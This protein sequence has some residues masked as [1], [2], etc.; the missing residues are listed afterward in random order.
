[1][2]DTITI[3]GT[4]YH[5]LV[6]FKD[7]ASTGN[8]GGGLFPWALV[9]YDRTK[10]LNDH[11]TEDTVD[12]T[13]ALSFNPGYFSENTESKYISFNQ[14]ENTPLDAIGSYITGHE[15]GGKIY[16]KLVCERDLRYTE[17]EQK[18]PSI[19]G[20]CTARAGLGA[21]QSLYIQ[22]GSSSNNAKEIL[23]WKNPNANQTTNIKETIPSPKNNNDIFHFYI[24]VSDGKRRV[25]LSVEPNNS[26]PD[27]F[28]TIEG[29]SINQ[30]TSVF[31]DYFNYYNGGPLNYNLFWNICK[32]AESNTTPIY[33][34]ITMDN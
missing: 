10:D 9:K 17:S 18:R 20:K 22:I 25:W 29:G 23:G 5:K 2:A 4:T 34:T 27:S 15:V 6:T 19:E 16:E 13:K 32:L 12:D 30:S 28:F 1:M 14:L 24:R 21:T 26:Q 3:N 33:F 8:G 7:C 31:S 11:K